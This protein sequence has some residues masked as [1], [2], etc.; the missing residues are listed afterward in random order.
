MKLQ[1]FRHE[2]EGN[3]RTA[4]TAT[5][6][7]DPGRLQPAAAVAHVARGKLPHSCYSTN[8]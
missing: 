2:P 5:V 7:D 8:Y 1:S 6:M 3:C 4:A